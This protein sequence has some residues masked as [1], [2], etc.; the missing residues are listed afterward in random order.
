MSPFFTV[1]AV[2]GLLPASVPARECVAR[3]ATARAA[4]RLAAPAALPAAS[5]SKVLVEADASAVA[6]AVMERVNVAAEAAI[7]ERGYFALV[8]PGGSILKMLKGMKPKW[9]SKTYLAYV[10]HKVD[11]PV[12]PAGRAIGRVVGQAHPRRGPVA[13]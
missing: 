3:V 12:A 1:A 10:N 13:M 2:L 7:A 4:V 6:A 11:T 8:I 5:P 9:A